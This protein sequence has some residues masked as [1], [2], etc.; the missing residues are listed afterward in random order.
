MNLTCIGR[1]I[2]VL[3]I[4]CAMSPAV[5]ADPGRS[6]AA[7]REQQAVL[8]VQFGEGRYVSYCVSFSEESITGLELLGRSG[9]DIATWGTAVCRIEQ[10]GCDYPAERCFCQCLAP[11]CRFWSY[12]QWREGHWIYSQVGAGY[13]G[14]HDGDVY[15]WVW[16]DGQSPPTVVPL[17]PPCPTAQ[18]ITGQGTLK[19]SPADVTRAEATVTPGPSP[20]LATDAAGDSALTANQSAPLAE[21]AAFAAISARLLGG[22]FFLRFRHQEP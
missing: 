10:F 14:V 15:G 4:L 3:A 6:A 5:G 8:V 11:P 22:F 21:Y 1:S 9:L 18:A 17:E 12:W 7:Q 19:P 16:G 2:L 13:H 20:P